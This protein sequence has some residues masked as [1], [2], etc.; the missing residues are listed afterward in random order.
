[1]SVQGGGYGGGQNGYGGGQDGSYGGG[2]GGGQ[3]GY[4]PNRGGYGAGPQN[5]GGN[6]G[7]PQWQGA[8]SS[9]AWQQDAAGT[10]GLPPKKKSPLPWILGGCGCLLVL[11]L[12]IVLVVVLVVLPGGGEDEGDD[13][14]T[15]RSET[16]EAPT[17][18]APTTDAPTTDAPT[19][20]APTTDAPTTDAPVG[21]VPATPAEVAG[22]TNSDTAA[23]TLWV[24]FTPDYTD[25][26]GVFFVEGLSPEMMAT[27]IA[28]PQVFGAWTCGLS[29]ETPVCIGGAHGGTVQL[30]GSSKSGADLAAWGDAFVAAWV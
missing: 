20:D 4:D 8:G 17:S 25:N 18:D 5:Q 11:L 21:A 19:T 6:N 2:Y 7:A 28:N 30:V 9:E 22:Y 16:T 12:A 29:E 10:G 27:G 24:Y 3:G 14:P 23:E 13:D 1:M 26:V 15:S